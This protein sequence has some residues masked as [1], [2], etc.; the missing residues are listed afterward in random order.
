MDA[1]VC[2]VECRDEKNA[3]DLAM[4]SFVLTWPIGTNR[5]QIR[6]LHIYLSHR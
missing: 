6:N 5:P 2:V 4:L 1:Y 3:S